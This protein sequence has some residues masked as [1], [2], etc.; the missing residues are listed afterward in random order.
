MLSYILKVTLCW[1]LFYLLYQAWL[2]KETF[3]SVNR[4]YLLGTVLLSLAIPAID[5]QWFIPVQEESTLVYYL[6]PITIGVDQ[7]ENVIFTASTDS[8]TINWWAGLTLVYW[9]GVVVA[10]FRFGY[11]LFSI[12]HLYLKGEKIVQQGYHFV[13]TPTP[14]VPFSFFK[15]LFWSKTFEVAETDRQSILRHE[16]AHIFQW[17]SLD[18]IFLEILGVIFW[19]SPFIYLYKKAVKTNHEY[20]ADNFVLAHASR[21]KY[22]RLLLRQSQSGMPIAITNSLFSSQLKQRI[23][24]MTKT[25]S[26]KTASLKYLFGLP[27]MA[28]MLLAFSF[29]QKAPELQGRIHPVYKSK[30]AVDTLPHGEIFKVVEE[31]PQ[32][33][34]CEEVA[35][36]GKR[37][38]CSQKK[39]LAFIYE[40][41]KYPKEAREAGTE[42]MV[43]VSFIV[44]KDGSIADAEIVRS[45]GSGC[46]EEVLRVVYLM[47]NWKPGKQNGK[48]VRVHYNLP[49][50]FK[51]DDD[52]KKIEKNYLGID[53]PPAFQGCE[54]LS[55]N[56]RQACTS[57]MAKHFIAQN[58]N[59]SEKAVKESISDILLAN[60]TIGADGIVKDVELE[61]RLGNGCDEEVIR[62]IKNMPKWTPAEKGGKP[63]EVVFHGMQLKFDFR[64]EP[65]VFKVVDEM[66]L[67]PG[68]EEVTEIGKR[69]LCSQK[70][71]LTFI[72]ENVK[73]PKEAREA[74]IEGMAV[75]RF[76]V[77]KDGSIADAEI[78]RSIGSG[79]DEEVLRVVY[80]MPNWTPG[81]QE[82]K[83]V[84]VQ[85]NL[86]VRFKLD[87]EAPSNKKIA[88]DH[89]PRFAACD[90]ADDKTK[91]ANSKMFDFILKNLK[92]P[93]T[94]KEDGVEGMVVVK[95]KVATDGAIQ[96]AEVIK[97]IGSSCDEEALRVVNLM[98]NWVAG[99][100]GGKAVNVEMKLPFKFALPQKA[101]AQKVEVFEVYP[102]PSSENGF[103]LKYQTKAGPIRLR[104]TDMAGRERSRIPIEDYD[105][106]VQEVR[107]DWVFQKNATRE[108]VVVSILDENGK[109]LKSTTVVIQ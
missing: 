88:G 28:L 105:G 63:T 82:G 96:E 49:V 27:L 60:F 91:C 22:G 59:F 76:V 9:I 79:C 57:K 62:T 18:I 1:S 78:V 61:Q 77:E 75:V 34:G 4:W 17:H 83:P 6:Q 99:V 11:G 86:P 74:G 31:M 8:K 3:F 37:N 73:Y 10:L 94:A 100:K 85:F 24:M 54:H 42:G 104:I 109:V 36:P 56:E 71:L 23:V 45:I 14:H 66:P 64:S 87:S 30:I 16:E 102:N 69:N 65:H 39:M 108:N 25:K 92:Y 43:V 26:T 33:P 2:S 46:D 44:E 38:L 81:K 58:V 19:C 41:V 53:I 103:T 97:G 68:C 70:K 51:L 35:D 50:K 55:G 13:S 48:K 80:L 107:F 93:E 106:T 29:G 40:N 89:M 95:F 72:Y 20:L 101:P 32:F 47:P 5:I 7:L 52:S 90:D 98:P 12:N 15:N 67:F 21:K 84:R